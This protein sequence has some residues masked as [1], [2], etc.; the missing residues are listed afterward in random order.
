MICRCSFVILS[1]L[2]LGS[3]LWSQP[4]FR[5]PVDRAGVSNLTGNLGE[6]RPDDINDPTVHLHHWHKGIDIPKTN[7]TTI[8]I[9]AAGK[10]TYI[11]KLPSQGQLNGRGIVVLHHGIDGN[12]I[13]WHTRF[14]HIAL[15]NSLEVGKILRSSDDGTMP[16]VGTVT[17]GHCHFEVYQFNAERNEND[18]YG[19]IGSVRNPLNYADLNNDAPDADNPTIEEIRFSLSNRWAENWDENHPENALEADDGQEKFLDPVEEEEYPVYFLAHAYDDI[20]DTGATGPYS[21]EFSMCM[22]QDCRWGKVSTFKY[23]FDDLRD[24]DGMDLQ[25]EEVYATGTQANNRT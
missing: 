3:P 1:L 20:T 7:G 9:P 25:L 22:H 15:R 17:Q 4:T 12:H 14:Y 10:V 2:V 8:R 23:Q 24:A 18:L 16:T 19:N 11:E 21:V 13:G 5:W 6:P